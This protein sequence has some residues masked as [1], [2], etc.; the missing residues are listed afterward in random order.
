MFIIIFTFYQIY[1]P[2]LQK[3]EERKQKQKNERSQCTKLV[4]FCF[5]CIVIILENYI[6][7]HI[8]H[9]FQNFECF[10]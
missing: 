3:K 7:L 9:R 8:K 4:L 6:N 5:A 2:N 1:H 10:D